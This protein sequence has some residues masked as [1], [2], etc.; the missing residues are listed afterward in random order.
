VE[1]KEICIDEIKDLIILGKEAVNELNKWASS[2]GFKLI[3]PEG[4]KKLKNCYKKRLICNKKGCFFRL[5]FISQE[6]NDFSEEQKTDELK[7]KLD[8]YTNVH[9]HELVFDQK[10]IFTSEIIREIDSLKGSAKSL[11]ELHRHINI[12]FQTTFNYYQILYQV[13]KLFEKNYGKADQDAHLLLD[14]VDKEIKNE[15]GFFEATFGEDKSLTK[16]VYLS[17]TMLCYAE[18]FLDMI[19]VDDYNFLRI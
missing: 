15:G 1:E 10:N 13:N 12:K 19:I 11:A 7:F 16:F 14:V 2:F 5:V 8:S 3:I 17:K 4:T 9:N 6:K 18:K